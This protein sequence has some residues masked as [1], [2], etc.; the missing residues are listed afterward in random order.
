MR[1][2]EEGKDS[3]DEN[4]KTIKEP[5]GV[6]RSHESN[7]MGWQIKRYKTN[8]STW[9]TNIDDF[10]PITSMASD[11]IL[12]LN[13]PTSIQKLGSVPWCLSITI[14]QTP[15]TIPQR[16]KQSDNHRFKL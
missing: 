15:F 2:A 3:H 6:I 16:T 4:F 7:L 13:L 8:T 12:S 1:V 10:Y 11:F 14:V 9:D 5:V